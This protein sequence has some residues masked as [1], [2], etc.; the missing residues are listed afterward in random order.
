MSRV[1]GRPALAVLR[2]RCPT[3]ALAGRTIV[4]DGRMFLVSIG[5]R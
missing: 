1:E 3:P 5:R 2:E 4:G